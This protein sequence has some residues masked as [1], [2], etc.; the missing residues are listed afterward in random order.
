M[1]QNLPFS[2]ASRYYRERLPAD[3]RCTRETLS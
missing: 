3:R 1:P 2:Q